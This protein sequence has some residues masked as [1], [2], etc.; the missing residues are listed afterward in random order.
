LTRRRP[1]KREYSQFREYLEAISEKARIL[2]NHFYNHGFNDD[3]PVK[4]AEVQNIAEKVYKLALSV[5]H[6]Y[7]FVA[8]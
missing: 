5:F 1:T 6:S 2:R 8:D 4:V 3:T 7:R